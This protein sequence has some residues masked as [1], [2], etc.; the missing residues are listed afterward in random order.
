MPAL[1][2]FFGLVFITALSGAQFQ[3]GEWYGALTKPPWN[4]PGWV[5]GP[6]W[7]LL[8]VLIALA[9][10]LVWRVERRVASPAMIAW[11][12]QLLLNGLWSWLFFGLQQPRLALIDI[13]ALLA[14]IV[15]FIVLARPISI[16]AGRLFFPYALWVSFAAALNFQI[17]QLNP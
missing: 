2:V 10:W 9:G 15:T 6:V 12:T 8:Y 13:F 14:A 1:I 11:F 4:P 16:T 7:T 5:F 17:V 3:P